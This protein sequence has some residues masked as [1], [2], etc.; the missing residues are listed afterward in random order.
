[1]N[2]LDNKG[3]SLL[4]H[5]IDNKNYPMLKRLLGLRIDPNQLDSQDNTPLHIAAKHADLTAVQMLT[6]AGANLD[7]PN[8]DNKR[9]IDMLP[10]LRPQRLHAIR[11]QLLP[12]G[13]RPAM[14]SVL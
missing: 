6:E 3:R 10:L 7:A 13:S 14:R 5:I 9:P 11:R 8:I 1:M 12:L 2:V 4:G